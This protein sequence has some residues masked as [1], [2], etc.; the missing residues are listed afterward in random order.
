LS[1]DRPKRVVTLRRDGD[2][3]VVLF[4]P[5]DIVVF[6]HND[7]SADIQDRDGGALLMATLLLPRVCSERNEIA[8]RLLR[9][10]AGTLSLSWFRLCRS[11]IDLAW[12]WIFLIFAVAN[13]G[14]VRIASWRSSF[15]MASKCG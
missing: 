7:A 4:Y 6:R 11:E 10:P 2:D 12:I 3:F 14:D 13:E 15:A 5:E 1:V 8:K 9:S